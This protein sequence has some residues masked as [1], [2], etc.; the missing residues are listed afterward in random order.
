MTV[1]GIDPIPVIRKLLASGELKH[2][3]SAELNGRKVERLV[4]TV[5]PMD[6]SPAVQ[7]EYLVDA[8]TYAP[9]RLATKSLQQ[10]LPG[11]DF[12]TYEELPLNA[13]TERL[14]VLQ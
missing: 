9:V 10:R 1:P 5:P 6:G 2:A 12:K 7:V 4:G 14:L 3:G 13:E 11:C 8:K